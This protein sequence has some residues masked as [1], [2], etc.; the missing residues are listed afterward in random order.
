MNI[1]FID[2]NP[3][4][5]AMDM[6][7]KHIVKMPLE[8]A[9]MLS[10]AH[11]L[12]DGK[13][14]Q[15]DSKQVYLLEGESLSDG[16]IQNQK[17]YKVAHKAHPC[18]VW[19]MQTV[20]NYLLHVKYLMAMLNE[21]K[22]RYQKV[23]AVEKMIPFL[24]HAPRNINRDSPEHIF[25]APPQCMPDK[26]KCEDYVT[27]YR[28][29]YAGEKFHFAKWKGNSELPEW[30]LHHMTLVWDKDEEKLLKL[31][32]CLSKKTLPADS[33]VILMAQELTYETFKDTL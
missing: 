3:D 31:N 14:T 26:Y 32:M 21:Y 17:C 12:L 22:A 16:E 10:T 2:A 9:Q 8:S 28:N 23:H 27:A 6:L 15:N 4:Y 7:D 13:L 30:F 18:T 11:R 33:R 25:T 5:A 24:R 29:F 20:G 1:F 19:T